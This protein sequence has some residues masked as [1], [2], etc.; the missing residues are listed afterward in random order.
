MSEGIKT[1]KENT[2]VDSI[3]VR[4]KRNDQNFESSTDQE[5]T[6]HTG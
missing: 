4:L 1:P 6:A 5:P 3:I 2:D